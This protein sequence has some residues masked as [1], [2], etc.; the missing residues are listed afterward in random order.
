MKRR[1]QEAIIPHMSGSCTARATKSVHARRCQASMLAFYNAIVSAASG[2]DLGPTGQA[3]GLGG[4]QRL[5]R[6]S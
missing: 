6:V 5:R 1:F 4:G 3:N 2:S